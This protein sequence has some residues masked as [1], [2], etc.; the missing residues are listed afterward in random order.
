MSGW[1]AGAVVAGAVIGGVASNSAARKS[2]K[3]ANRATDATTARYYQTRDDLLPYNEQGQQASSQLSDFVKDPNNTNFTAQD[4]QKYQDPSYQWQLQQGQQALQNSQA[5]GD[6]VL[7]GA[8][9]KGM[10]NY[11]QGLASTNYQN[12]YNN[13]FNT[14][15]QNYTRL[16]NLANLGEN[17]AAQTGSTG[18]SLANTAANSVMAAGNAGAAGI[19][20]AGNAVTGSIN[21]GMGYYMMNNL[22]HPNSQPDLSTPITLNGS[23]GIATGGS[24]TGSS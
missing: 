7:S 6:G 12:A 3:A 20:G 22:L 16:F 15:N 18:A 17:A 1:V 21:N 13:W 10:Q 4:F 2:A 9:L 5:A 23:Q 19:I 8:A 24:F 11:T 14:T